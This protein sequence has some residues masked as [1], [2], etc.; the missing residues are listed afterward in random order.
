MVSILS[1]VIIPALFPA[2]SN[3]IDPTTGNKPSSNA[4]APTLSAEERGDNRQTAD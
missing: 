3:F 2:Q 1:L 4:P